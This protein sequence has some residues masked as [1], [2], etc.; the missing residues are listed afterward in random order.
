MNPSQCTPQRRS[1]SVGR[2]W[3]PVAAIVFLV[4]AGAARGQE[5]EP[6]RWGHLPIGANFAGIGYVYTD[7]GISL[8]P[9]LRIEDATFEMKSM[10][11]KY[12]H[13]FELIGKSARFELTQAYQQGTWSGLLDGMPTSV[14]RSGWGDTVL[15]FAVN[16][17]GAPPLRGE[18]FAAYRAGADRETIFGAG[19]AVSLPTGEYFDDRLINLGANRF[20][21]RPQVGFVHGWGNWSVE[22]TGALWIFTDN[23]DFWNGNRVEQ[24]PLLAMQSHLIYTFRPGLWLGASLGY[25]I[26]GRS[27]VNGDAKDDRRN[28]LSWALSLGL[29]VNRHV[30]VKLGY[31]GSR[32]GERIGSDSDSIVAAVS[33]L[34]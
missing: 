13:S 34:W 8:D 23:N 6:R 11:L 26:G 16:L 29:P 5:L 7:G 32:S 25:D 20:S 12:I 31:I 28:Q 19:L 9:V 27:T 15:R 21:L 4:V 10:A 30:G 18:E 14:D 22:F 33:V 2:R 17:Y 1:G 3:R 24:D